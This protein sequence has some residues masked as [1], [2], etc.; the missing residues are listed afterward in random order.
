MENLKKILD[1][2]LSDQ[3]ERLSKRTYNDYRNVIELFEDYLNSYAYMHLSEEEQEDFEE[4]SIFGAESF[5]EMYSADKLGS[6][7]VDAFLTDFLIRKVMAQKS[8]MKKAI[9]VMRKFSKWL[10]NN[11]YIDDDK[12]KKIYSTINE[13]KDDL[14]K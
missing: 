1:D 9:T 12:F 11:N 8:L 2:F 3:D 10:K 14:S 5:C 4:K 7:E 6:M 13:N